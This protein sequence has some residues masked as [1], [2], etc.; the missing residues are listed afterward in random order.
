MP[1]PGTSSSSNRITG[2]KHW[3]ATVPIANQSAG[4]RNS[5]CTFRGQERSTYSV[6]FKT[7]GFPVPRPWFIWQRGPNKGFYRL[8]ICQIPHQ[9]D[10]VNPVHTA[11]SSHQSPAGEWQRAPYRRPTSYCR[12]VTAPILQRRYD[13]EPDQ[14]QVVDVMLWAW[15]LLARMRS[16]WCWK[17]CAAHPVGLRCRRVGLPITRSRRL[18]RV[19]SGRLPR[20]RADPASGKIRLC[21][22]RPTHIRWR[23]IP[24]LGLVGACWLLL[25]YVLCT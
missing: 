3:R 14:K 25:M 22:C 2:R 15:V 20:P 13:R 8:L 10:A 18:S 19:G 6:Q 9:R 21:W 23:V 5:T 7:T 4:S 12:K 16:C 24:D 11:G 1:T 17:G